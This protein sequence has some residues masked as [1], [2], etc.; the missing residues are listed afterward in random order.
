MKHLNPLPSTEFVSKYKFMCAIPE[1]QSRSVN[2]IKVF[3]TPT[4]GDKQI[5]AQLAKQWLTTFLSIQEMVNY[6]KEGVSIRIRAKSDVALMYDYIS[7]YLQAWKTFLNEGLNIGEAPID[8]LIAMDRFAN[9]VYEHAKY[10]FTRQIADSI[11]AKNLTST[12]RFNKNNFFK[13]NSKAYNEFMGTGLKQPEREQEY[14]ERSSF[15]DTFRD[16]K[17]N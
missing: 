3:G 5:D 7:K 16:K 17:W 4:T 10:Q 13:E 14:P 15:A 8:E 6:H 11:I 12:V 9:E 2:H 1:L